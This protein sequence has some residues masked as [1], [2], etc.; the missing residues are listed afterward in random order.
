[1]R[2]T[3]CLGILLLLAASGCT[4]A[5]SAPTSSTSTEATVPVTSSTS[6]PAATSTSE[7]PPDPGP[8]PSVEAV[9]DY[10]GDGFD[11]AAAVAVA[12]DGGFVTSLD[13]RSS[14]SDNGD[15]V[16]L[17]HAADG[18][19]EWSRG[20]GGELEDTPLRNTVAVD[21]SGAV[22]V[23]GVIYDT[24]TR[25]RDLVVF[26]SDPEGE[27]LWQ[28][29]GLGIEG[30]QRP[31]VVAVGGDGSVYVGGH[32]DL[33]GVEGHDH[34]AMLLRFGP[35][36][37]SMWQLG[38]AG[39]GS[40]ETAYSGALDSEDNFVVAGTVGVAGEI[41]AVVVK[42]APDG[43]VLWQRSWGMPGPPERAW[44][45]VTDPDDNIYVSGPVVGIGN[46]GDATFVIKVDPDG[47]LVWART[48]TVSGNEV[49]GHGAAFDDGA[50]IV[51]GFIRTVA[52]DGVRL[53]DSGYLLGISSDGELLWQAAVGSRGIESIEG[54]EFLPGGALLAVGQGARNDLQVVPLSGVWEPSDV[55][56]AETAL[57]VIALD[58][59]FVDGYL[60]P[61]PGPAG[62]GSGADAVIIRLDL[63]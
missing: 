16:V 7:A 35:S 52:G 5:E 32:H 9:V 61:Q 41:D 60:E 20:W 36:G 55:A 1:M 63:P 58:L 40:A 48:W 21:E 46:G 22:H 53:D 43:G 54:L 26:K 47:N 49:W 50:L 44:D 62:P 39:D 24:G 10:G 15:I 11:Y 38:L 34:I 42:V 33:Q 28:R 3:T 12:P 56:L 31:H 51:S 19:L 23:A 6:I 25:Q 29:A 57:E 13:Y 2:R 27:L 4:G 17:K 45:V 37:E 59:E 30:D 14:D 18:S 8:L